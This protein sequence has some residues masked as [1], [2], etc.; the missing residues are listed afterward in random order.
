MSPSASL[1]NV[2]KPQVT[3]LHQIFISLGSNIQRDYHTRSGLNALSNAFG[4]LQLSSVFESEAVG[5]VGRPFYN[6]VVAAKT[7]LSIAQV[8]QTLKQ[9][10]LDNGRVHGAKKFAPRTLDLDLLLYDDVVTEQGVNLPRAEILYNAFVLQPL[11][12]LAADLCHPINGQSY[13]ALW[14]AFDK[15]SQQ[16]WPITFTWDPCR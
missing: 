11:A 8:C 4:E 16:L 3:S 6:L 12:E 14:Q 5:F 1:H 9:I 10:E 7:S 15:N 13:A 2:S